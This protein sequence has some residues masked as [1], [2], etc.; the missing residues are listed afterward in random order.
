MVKSNL[1]I[2]YLFLII[3]LLNNCF[4]QEKIVKSVSISGA[5]SNGNKIVFFNNEIMNVNFDELS[6]KPYNFYYS[7]EH[8]DYN[9]ELSNIFKNEYITGFDDIRI[10][11]IKIHLILYRNLLVTHLI[12]LT[13]I[14]K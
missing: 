10:M 7:V 8:Y 14:S 12:S 13:E 3:F 11:T 6:A 9:W 4:S 1:F 5:P 2:N